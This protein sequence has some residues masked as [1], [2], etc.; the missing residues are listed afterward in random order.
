MKTSAI[1][2]GS[3]KPKNA[4]LEEAMCICGCWSNL[5]FEWRMKSLLKANELG[6]N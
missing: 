5:S 4:K 3:V 6:K 1:Q 2:K